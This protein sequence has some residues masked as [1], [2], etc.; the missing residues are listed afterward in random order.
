MKHVTVEKLLSE[1]GAERRS[2]GEA[3]LTKSASRFAKRAEELIERDAPQLLP[4]TNAA[5]D[6]WNP[7]WAMVEEVA[8]ELEA[9]ETD[10]WWEIQRRWG[11]LTADGRR[12]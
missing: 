10:R 8:G 9:A 5:P 6:E 12:A 2:L 3:M 7:Y 1:L 11:V 4:S